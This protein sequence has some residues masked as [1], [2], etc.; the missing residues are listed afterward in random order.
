MSEDS[1]VCMSCGERDI[2]PDSHECRKHT[3]RLA[4]PTPN[5][6]NLEKQ[7]LHT[8]RQDSRTYARLIKLDMEEMEFR[9]RT[10]ESPET[11]V[12][13]LGNMLANIAELNSL[14]QSERTAWREGSNT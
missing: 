5:I 14:V 11:L 13:L 4:S 10:G 6:K 2:E 8:Y 1:F 9:M 7:R 12:Q 3:G